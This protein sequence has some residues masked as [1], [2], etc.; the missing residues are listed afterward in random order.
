MLPPNPEY[1]FDRDYRE[2]VRLGDGTRA[3]LRLIRPNDKEALRRGFE[4]LSTSSRYLRF[5]MSKPCLTDDELHYLVNVDNVDHL[6]LVAATLETPAEEEGLGVA[7]YV[8]LAGRPQVAEAAVTVVDHAQGKGLASLLLTRLAAAARERGVE[9]FTCDFMAANQ[10]VLRLLEKYADDTVFEYDGDVVH[11]EVLIPDLPPSATP[12]P[13][14]RRG[15][16]FRL[17]GDTARGNIEIR[18]RHLLLKPRGR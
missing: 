6:A 5:F 12:T 18:L 13:G 9:R 14:E 11:A 10:P 7:R 8:R 4:R 2:E 1:H 15:V 17:L 16:M 3:L